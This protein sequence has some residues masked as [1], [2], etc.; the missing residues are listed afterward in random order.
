MEGT[1]HNLF[2]TSEAAS[3][4][5]QSDFVLRLTEYLRSWFKHTGYDQTYGNLE[6]LMVKSCYFKSQPKAIQIF[7]KERGQKLTLEQMVTFSELHRDVL[8][9]MPG[10]NKSGS[11]FLS[12]KNEN[13]SSDKANYGNLVSVTKNV[14]RVVKSVPTYSKNVAG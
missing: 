8:G 7:I 3:F 6:T 12:S 14:D 11:K 1:F 9:K 13:T 2:E 4:E 5:S 10:Q